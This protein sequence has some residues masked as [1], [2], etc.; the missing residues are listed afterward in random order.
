ML[1]RMLDGGGT[2]I[3][4]AGMARSGAGTG[5]LEGACRC[6]SG[7]TLRSGFSGC[8]QGVPASSL[9]SRHGRIMG[10]AATVRPSLLH[11]GTAA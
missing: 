4:R 10:G 11:I 8:W 7:I 9:S 6:C 1:S 5:A 3:A 2:S